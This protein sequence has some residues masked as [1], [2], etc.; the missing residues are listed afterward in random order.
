MKDILIQIGSYLFVFIM[1]MMII[2]FLTKGY[3]FKYIQVKAGRG[4]KVLI[5][6]ESPTGIYYQAGHFKDKNLVYKYMDGSKGTLTQDLK[7]CIYYEMGVPCIDLDEKTGKVIDKVNKT[8][9][10]GCDPQKTDQDIARAYER[11]T[12]IDKKENLMLLLQIII[13][14]VLAIGAFMLKNLADKVANLNVIG[15]V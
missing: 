14:I 11:P 3:V 15:V 6:L 10:S 9:V 12:V 8:E 5:R 13:I 1:A 4:K 2:N 7:K